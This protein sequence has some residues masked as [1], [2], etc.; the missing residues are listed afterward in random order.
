MKNNQDVYNRNCKLNL[1]K[2]E[3]IEYVNKEHQE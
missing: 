2:H 3:M 1:A